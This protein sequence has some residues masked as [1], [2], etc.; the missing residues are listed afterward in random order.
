M[1]ER[2]RLGDVAEEPGFD[3]ANKALQVFTPEQYPRGYVHLQTLIGDQHLAHRRWK[4][5]ASAYLSAI[6]VRDHVDFEVYSREGQELNAADRQDVHALAGYALFNLG[7]IFEASKVIDSGRARLLA[8]AMSA[9]NPE[10]SSGVDE[11]LAE[12][13]RSARREFER[14]YRSQLQSD[15]MASADERKTILDTVKDARAIL[16]KALIKIKGS[17]SKEGW[18]LSTLKSMIPKG[19]ALV[20]LTTTREGSFGIIFTGDGK[21]PKGARFKEFSKKDIEEWLY[22]S[23]DRI[24]WVAAQK[25]QLDNPNRFKDIIRGLCCGLWDRLIGPLAQELEQL[26]V[27]PG[28]SVVI[29]AGGNLATLPLHGAMRVVNGRERVFLEDFI[30]SYAPCISALQASLTPMYAHD[31][32]NRMLIIRDPESDLSFAELEVSEVASISG[33]S[34]MSVV[35]L[36]H[37]GIG[38]LPLLSEQT[39]LHIACHGHFDWSNPLES[40]LE[41]SRTD[42]VKLKQILGGARQT[43]RLVFLSACETGISDLNRVPEEFIGFRSAFLEAGAHSVIGT[44]WCVPDLS[45]MLL[46]RRFYEAYFADGNSAASALRRAQIWLRDIKGEELIKEIELLRARYGRQLSKTESK[47]DGLCRALTRLSQ[48]RVF[49]HPYY[50]AGFALSGAS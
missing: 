42:S 45:T 22:G 15:R 28:S 41:F 2:A 35:P 5:A 24:G 3:H 29:L 27:R 31:G 20:Q 23:N 21:A 48:T 39:Y 12:I 10:D 34:N 11:K 6:G 19:G 37:D 9:N 43:S 32:S 49:D 13:V 30:I 46:V 18:N 40:T 8:A 25:Q 26:E 50:W 16:D 38:V 14:A 47:L 17:P 1:F 7:E 44:L 36:K 4:E 33:S